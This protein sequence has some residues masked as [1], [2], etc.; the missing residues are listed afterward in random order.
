MTEVRTCELCGTPY[1]GPP[2][3]KG[4]LGPL[5]LCWTCCVEVANLLG[6]DPSIWEEVIA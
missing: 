2:R 3:M 5:Y 4:G 1:A 6:E